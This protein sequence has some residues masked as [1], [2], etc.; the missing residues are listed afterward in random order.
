M[1]ALLLHV[2]CVFQPHANPFF[3][4]SHLIYWQLCC[5]CKIETLCIFRNQKYSKYDYRNQIRWH[6]NAIVNQALYRT[7]SLVTFWSYKHQAFWKTRLL[8]GSLIA[9]YYSTCNKM[10]AIWGLFF[11]SRMFKNDL[12]EKSWWWFSF[13]MYHHHIQVSDGSL[14][15]I[16]CTIAVGAWNISGAGVG[17]QICTKGLHWKKSGD[18]AEM[19]W[20]KFCPQQFQMIVLDEYYRIW[21]QT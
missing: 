7:M 16:P 21:I 9:R 1:A 4:F 6:R 2:T 5:F 20:S 14:M 12:T 15:F 11:I 18:E 13:N 17:V 3:S 10:H 19:K 8:P